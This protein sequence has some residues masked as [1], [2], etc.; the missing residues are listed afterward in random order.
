MSTGENVQKWTRYFLLFFPTHP[1]DEYDN[2]HRVGNTRVH[3]WTFSPVSVKRHLK[4]RNLRKFIESN[5]ILCKLKFDYSMK[6][7]LLMGQTYSITQLTEILQIPEKFQSLKF[8]RRS[9]FFENNF[10]QNFFIQKNV[11]IFSRHLIR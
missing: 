5:K 10:S 8:W 6:L 3:F 11:H 7:A 1:S 2:Q 4:I 9:D